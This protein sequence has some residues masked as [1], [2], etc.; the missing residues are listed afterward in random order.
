MLDLISIA[1]LAA[2]YLAKGAD[3]LSKTAGEKIGGLVSDLCQAVAN[4][5]KG[6][7]Y[8]EKT[9]DRAKE[10][11]ESKGRQEALKEVLKEKMED[12]QDFAE[13]VKNLMDEVK[14]ED[15]RTRFD[16]RGQTIQG[17]QTNI[18]TANGPVLSGTFSGSVNVGDAGRG[19]N[20]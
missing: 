12:D 17:P 8:A 9:L 20:Q 19:K 4:K 3:A 1:A 13:K 7:S 10:E 16:Q 5:F 11:P 6:D 2:P 18:G 14:R 15:S